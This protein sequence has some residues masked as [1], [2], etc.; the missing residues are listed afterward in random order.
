MLKRIANYYESASASINDVP[1]PNATVVSPS[2][3]NISDDSI[4]EVSR[5]TIALHILIKLQDESL[6]LGCME[7]KETEN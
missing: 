6:C 3:E 1:V 5:S 2:D 4:S 7:K